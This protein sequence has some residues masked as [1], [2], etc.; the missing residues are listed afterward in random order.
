[1]QNTSKRSWNKPELKK[2]G[3]LHDVAGTGIASDQSVGNAQGVGNGR[4]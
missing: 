3:T 1:M 4:S 2:V